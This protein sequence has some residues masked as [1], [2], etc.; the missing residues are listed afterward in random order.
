MLSG[1]FEISAAA[2]APF[3]VSGGIILR[4]LLEDAVM[5]LLL[6]GKADGEYLQLFLRH[7]CRGGVVRR[8]RVQ[9]PHAEAVAQGGR[10]V[11]LRLLQRRPGG[12]DLS[13]QRR[14]R[15]R[16]R[17]ELQPL[18]VLLAVRRRHGPEVRP[19]RPRVA[20]VVFTLVLSPDPRCCHRRR[21]R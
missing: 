5:L 10:L 18:L 11:D 12:R 15:R 6:S 2:F 13:A 14:R 4:P 20:A 21:C 8:H 19:V 7:H 16:R 9:P 1:L 3:V 17:R